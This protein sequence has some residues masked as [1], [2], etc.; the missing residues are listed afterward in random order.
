MCDT[1]KHGTKCYLYCNGPQ[2]ILWVLI[3]QTE[4]SSHRQLF[5]IIVPAGYSVQ[6]LVVTEEHI[7]FLYD[8]WED[9]MR[10]K[11]ANEA[12]SLQIG[13]KQ[14]ILIFNLF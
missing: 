12:T 4:T 3:Q 8:R 7:P 6:R 10:Y 1:V 2:F 14:K 5:P 13:C 9:M 11:M